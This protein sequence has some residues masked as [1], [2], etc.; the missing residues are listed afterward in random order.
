M[1]DVRRQPPKND[2]L[3]PDMMKHLL[4]LIALSIFSLKSIGQQT[5]LD[6]LIQKIKVSYPGYAEKTK[7]L[8]FDKFV[9]QTIAANNRDTFKMMSKIVGFFRDRHLDLFQTLNAIDTDNKKRNFVE[10]MRYFQSHK[11]LK[12]YEGFWVNESNFYVIAIIQ[13]K[14]ISGRYKGIIVECRDSS[15]AAEGTLLYTFD[16]ESGNYFYTKAISLASSTAFY[17]HAYFR[18]DSVMTGGPYNKWKKLSSYTTPLLAN[19]PEISDT[20]SGRW[21][22]SNNFLITIPS[23]T[24]Y[25][26]QV[27]DN[28]IRENPAITKSVENLIVDLRGNTGGTVRAFTSLI[29][30]LYTNP[31]LEINCGQ[32]CT[33]DGINRTRQRIIDLE[34]NHADTIE[35]KEWKDWLKKQE[36]SIGHFIY[37]DQD[38][39]K[40]DSQFTYPKH[41]G[42]I[43]DYGCQS[44]TEIFLLQALQSKKVTLFGEPTMGAIDYLDYY[45]VN[46]PSGKY[47]LYIA[48]TKRIIPKGGKKLDG[49]GFQPKVKIN[50]SVKDWV[51]FVKQY[52]EKN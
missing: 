16:K 39:L 49:I 31:I 47:Q 11:K 10:A 14:E 19:L 8:D 50:D 1:Q 28:I 9:N 48:S 13:D 27:V 25:N 23:S 35:I 26:G 24:V 42:L 6:F 12:K 20:A 3:L 4:L 41:V 7:G 18:S 15:L 51:E 38:T 33:P 45:P 40:F 29:P 34:R 2:R 46:L 52:Y 37:F 30:L 5:D 17:I 44:A 36:D 22:D 32:Y 21:L 43:I